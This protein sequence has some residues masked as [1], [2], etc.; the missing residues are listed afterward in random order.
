MA[1]YIGNKTVLDDNVVKASV[2]AAT[3]SNTFT[4]ADHSKLNAIEASATADQTAAELL[5]AIKTVDGTGTGLDSD[6]LDGQEG[7]YY[8]GYADT[9][10]ANLVDSSPAALNTLNELAAA[11]GDDANF[12]T[13]TATSL[14]EK[15][16]KAGGEM[17]GNITMSGSQTVD[18]RDLSVDGAKLDLIEASATADQT[19]AEIRAAVEA[20]TDSNVF[21]DADHTKLNSI[22]ASATADQ[23]AAEIRTLVESASDSN[24][25]TDADHTKLDGVAASANNYVHPNHSGEITSTA[26]GATV[27]ADNTV[28]EANL[29]I[30]NAPVNGYVLTAQSGNTG[31]LTWAESSADPTRGTLTKSFTS[32][33]TASITLSAA[34]SPTPVVSATKEVPQS[35]VV[36]KG[37]WDV[38]STGTNYDRMDTAYNTTLTPGLEGWDVSTASYSQNFSVSSQTTSPSGVFFKPDGSKMYVIDDGGTDSV[39]EYN[40]STA[41][42]VSTASFSQD[43]SAQT[44]DTSPTDVFFKPDGT[45]MYILGDAGNDIN[46]YNLSTAWDISTASYSQNF[47][48]GS[49]EANPQGLFFKPDGTKMYVAGFGSARVHEYDLS[50]AWDISTA[51][52]NQNFYVAN[53]DGNPMSIFFKPNGTKMYF[54]GNSANSVNEY[55]LSTAWDVS[56]ASFLQSLSIGPQEINPRG[57]FFKPDGIKMYVVGSTG[58]DVNEYNLA[59]SSLLLLGTGSFASTDVGK[60]IEGNNGVV[61]LTATDGSYV[62]TTAFTDSSTIAAGSWSM[63]FVAINATNGLEMSNGVFDAFDIANIPTNISPESKDLSSYVSG[64]TLSESS[65]VFKPDGLKVFFMA[66][67]GNPMRVF[68]FTLTTAFDA[69]TIQTGS[70]AYYDFV[71][72]THRGEGL[73]FK[74]DG[75]CFYYDDFTLQRFI[76]VPLT[77]PW[78][79]STAGTEQDFSTNDY[80]EYG[81]TISSDGTKVYAVDGNADIYSYDFGTAWDITTLT[82]K[83][84]NTT[85][86]ASTPMYHLTLNADDTK[87]YFVDMSKYMREYTFGTKGDIS[88]LTLTQSSPRFY[89]ELSNFVNSYLTGLAFNSTGTKFGVF[90]EASI[91]YTF[92]VGTTVSGTGYVP[93]ITNS[94]GQIDSQYWTDINTMTTDEISGDG[95]VHYAVSTDNRTTWSVIKEGT[96]VRPI[97]RNNS[98]TWQYN[99]AIVGWDISTASFLQSFS[100][101]S[102]E[103][104]PRDVFFKPDGTK[105]Y[106]IG[107]DGD[108][109]YEY[110][111]STAWD[112][113]TASYNSV[114]FSVAAQESF[115]TNILFK[116]DGLKMY[117]LGASGDDVNEYNLSTAWDISTASYSQNFSVSSQETGP[118]GLFFKPDGTKMYISGFS[119]DDVNEYDLSTAWDISTASYSQNFSVAAQDTNVNGTFFKTDGLKMYVVGSTGDAVYEYNLSTAWDISTASYSQTFSVAAQDSFPTN[120]F[121]KPDGLKMYVVGHVYDAVYEYDVGSVDYTTA[122]TWANSTTNSELYALQQALTSLSI[123]RMD[124]TQLE[125]V[126]DPNHYTLG[127][128]LDLMISLHMASASSSVPSSDGVSI[129]YDAATINQGA[130]LGTDYDYD[131]PNS[132]TVRVTSNA[133]QNLKVRV[134]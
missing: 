17:T 9:A 74:P 21:T 58:D 72:S 27:I 33:E 89:Y 77:T 11:L 76:Q 122:T 55:N 41:W 22:E 15:L 85:V 119:G 82:N 121:F 60:T 34:V 80:F 38:S 46:E 75:T 4:D 124:K 35:G 112:V 134:V 20:A 79:L 28:D 84:Q 13:T 73:T 105:M 98:G 95:A 125:A 12:A 91:I 71:G 54:V 50:T 127:D 120:I 24:V 32:G 130:I 115:P 67:S 78:D 1:G 61:V 64:Y 97:V 39:H 49:Q 114:S 90:T 133:A 66:R 101:A 14:G 63:N 86:L 81:F 25:F 83:Q 37:A 23:T 70:A 43:F 62:A 118:Q 113:S 5:T 116:P 30:S 104:K 26:D 96:G 87:L 131:F 19:D 7:S 68:S 53:E 47:S 6:L 111:L 107:Y 18:G 40:L 56:T 2:E 65:L 51:S 31:G 108:A 92:D 129:N 36:S 69:S 59:S 123:N 42:D 57:I 126:T 3:D 106:V 94:G 117:I 100:V 132:T 102:Q 52:I 88:T 110:S 16:P 44:Q 48:V 8:T 93:S 29:K 10:V 45:K 128:S 99:E 103:I 109:V